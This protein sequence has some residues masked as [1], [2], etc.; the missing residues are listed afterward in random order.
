VSLRRHANLGGDIGLAPIVV[1]LLAFG[2]ALI[3]YFN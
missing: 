3:N 2:L 1:A